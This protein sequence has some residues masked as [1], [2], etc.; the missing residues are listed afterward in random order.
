MFALTVRGLAARKFRTAMTA[1]AVF[2]GV[3]LISG[4]YILT[5]TINRTF[6]GIFATAAQG[7]DVS[8]TPKET[9]TQNGNPPGFSQALLAK[10][11]ATDGVAKAAGGVFDQAA[12]LNKQG[13]PI[14]TKAPSFVTAAE[15]APFDPFRYTEGRAPAGPGEAA[16]DASAAQKAGYRLGDRVVIAGN[17]PKRAFRLVGIVTFGSSNSLAG[18]SAAV[19]TLPEAQ[20]VL[21]Q[22]G[23]LESIDVQTRAGTSPQA[24]IARLRAVL[25]ATVTVRTGEQ[26][27][28]S[29]AKDT[30]GGFSFLTTLLLVFAGIALFV[31]AFMI[32]NTFSITTAQRTRE[33]ALLRTL[34]ATRRQV[35]RAVVG[36]ALV[37]GLLASALG[38]AAGLVIAPAL[39]GL[40]K[41][42][43]ADLPAQGTVVQPRTIVVS[44]LV[45]TLVTLAASLP[46]AL[47]ATRVPP[48]AA[49]REGAT[50]PAGRL[51]RLRTPFGIAVA[52]VGVLL[53]CLGLFGDGGLAL[54]GAGAGVVFLGA[55][56]LSRYVVRPLAGL[57]GAPMRRLH[58]VTGLLARENATRNA[59]RTASTAA[60]LMIGLALV[61]FVSIF[62]AGA[63][64]SVDAA[65]DS[66]FSGAFV[67]KSSS[68]FGTVP[69]TAAASIRAVPGVARVAQV[70]SV[71]TKVKG[72][73]GTAQVSGIDTVNLLPMFTFGWVKGSEA[74]LGA[75]GSRGAAISKQY[76]E[77]H[78]LK[79]GAPIVAV[80]AQGRR[81]PLVVRG[82]YDD[83]SDLLGD[84]T[85]SLAVARS[86]FGA[87]QDQVAFV[88]TAPGASQAAVGQ[89][90]SR[91]LAA[92]Y[93]TV[94]SQTK[95]EYKDDVASQINQLLS[96][97]YV[98]LSLSV[99]VSLFGI[100]NTL[101][102]SIYERTRE[103][104][105]LRAVGMSRRQVRTMVRYEAVITAMI[106]AV[107]GLG[108]GV[109]F[110]AVM[111]PA[112][113]DEGW[114]FVLP[115]GTLVALLVL[116]ALA[117]VL[118]AIAPARR[119]AKLDVLDALAY[120]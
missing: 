89:R 87:T 53:R 57:I 116:A 86:G 48:V 24:V 54:V 68:G 73:G 76:A 113:E 56:M 109:F 40:F 36:E 114:V 71:E 9:F 21:D 39:K 74:V 46:P 70:R 51:A 26:Q 22:R 35:L 105:L 13:D 2:L 84:I 31:G 67:V 59:A 64:A 88:A 120:E 60:A 103:L 112:L 43:G 63:K 17:G 99:I 23:S 79:V 30:K 77:S 10:V 11:R 72:I 83:K 28:Q 27:A 37:V 106:G 119:A 42:F 81:V 15:P 20:A 5:D 85:V 92:R 75:L 41:A 118:A 96:F 102:L 52:A 25:P 32:F 93:P 58:G 7:V 115:G 38:L 66:G 16:L 62:A 111:T 69:A 50:L 3:A 97:F 117:G 12:I 94:E 47:R 90:I 19:L 101:A 34:G 6:D 18:A 110:A 29:Q 14:S 98:L 65:V 107:L 80:S 45:G 33:F 55:A 78:G 44:L 95:Q 4:T 108:L 100:V 49:L 61:T 82:V 8:V 91:L 104:G 1:A